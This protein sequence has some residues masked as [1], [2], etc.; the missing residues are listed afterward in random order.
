MHKYKFIKILYGKE[1]FFS[2]GIMKIGEKC[3]MTFTYR[4]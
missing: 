3:R 1:M 4:Q 2:M